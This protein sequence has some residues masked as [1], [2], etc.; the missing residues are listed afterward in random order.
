MLAIEPQ[1]C[2]TATKGAPE[3][4]VLLGTAVAV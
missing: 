4:F 2:H 3:P 1:D